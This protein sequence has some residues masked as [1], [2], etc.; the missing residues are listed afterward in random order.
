MKYGLG[1]LPSP[2][3]RR[4]YSVA[5]FYPVKESPGWEPKH[6]LKPG[7]QGSVGACVAYGM[8]H[9]TADHEYRETGKLR[10]FDPN[11][12]YGYREADHHQGEGMFP[13]Q[14]LQTLRRNGMPVLGHLPWDQARPYS[15]LK[16]YTIS[17]L[18]H[19]NAMYQ[20]V[21]SFFSAQSWPEVDTALQY[22]QVPIVI[23]VY[24]SFVHC[25]AN[26]ELVR[27]DEATERSYGLHLVNVVYKRP[28]G[29]YAFQ[30]WWGPTWGDQSMAGYCMGYL[31]QD[32]PIYEK[33]GVIDEP[34]PRKERTIHL[35][36]NNPIARVDG[37]ECYIDP[38]NANVRAYAE[39]GRTMVPIRFVAEALGAEVGYED[40][41]KTVTIKAVVS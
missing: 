32:Y 3:D 20:R 30:H 9:M 12:T 29:R 6:L 22:G 24:D 41:T 14:A 35:I 7:Y 13:R 16:D 31:P 40:A 18:A 5:S 33:W 37:K 26:G 8:E 10:R 27:P 25:P 28:D 34:L 21:Q 36:L 38:Y 39:Q 1:A 17:A 2:H 23:P 19:A 4:D 15:E 11:Y